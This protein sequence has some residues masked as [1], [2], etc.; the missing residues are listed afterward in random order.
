MTE[1]LTNQNGAPYLHIDSK[2]EGK[3]KK[4]NGK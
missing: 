4:L 1:N 3:K 2:S